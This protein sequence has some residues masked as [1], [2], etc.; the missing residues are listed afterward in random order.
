MRVAVTYIPGV[1]H[2]HAV[3]GAYLALRRAGHDAVLCGSREIAAESVM[4]REGEGAADALSS[5]L[6]MEVVPVGLPRYPH[7]GGAIDRSGV[8]EQVSMCAYRDLVAYW[9]M[10]RPDL[11]VRDTVDRGAVLAA[12]ACGVPYVSVISSG[13]ALF[14]RT[15]DNEAV[16]LA[17]LRP[18][19]GLAR[20]GVREL[21][22]GIVSFGPGRFFRGQLDLP[23]VRSFRYSPPASRGSSHQG[24]MDRKA[25]AIIVFGTWA[26]EPG[27]E[28]FENFILGLTDAG[29]A[30]VV[31]K[32]RNQETRERLAARGLERF[33]AGVGGGD[34]F[35][36]LAHCALFV[37]HG[38]AISTLE[39]LY[40]G[41]APLM[42]PLQADNF[43]TALRCVSEGLG[44]YLRAE[45]VTRAAVARAATHLR[46]DGVRQ[47]IKE[48]CLENDSLP[49]ADEFVA[50]LADR[51]ETWL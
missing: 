48:F 49:S 15:Q 47:R 26:R 38:S 4:L 19:G 17:R 10:F 28:V 13:D 6:A 46:S 23:V 43:F 36:Q 51:H 33:L 37:S 11:V 50:W 7:E 8:I 39:G 31:C 27:W 22:R 5:P 18:L 40:Y 12:E 1:G 35:A 16:R 41:V 42:I 20:H 29:I 44:T 34:V 32:V 3:L 9:Q 45:A 24:G 30:E 14:P 25:L 21:D 2:L